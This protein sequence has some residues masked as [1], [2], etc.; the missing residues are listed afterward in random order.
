MEFEQH[1]SGSTTAPTEQ[2]IYPALER[3]TDLLNERVEIRWDDGE[4]YP[5][6]L[7][8]V[9]SSDSG[10]VG[11]VVSFDNEDFE[12]EVIGS[13]DIRLLVQTIDQSTVD[14]E[15]R[16]APV[17]VAGAFDFKSFN[18]YVRWILFPAK[19]VVLSS[20]S[21]S[22]S[23]DEGTDLNEACRPKET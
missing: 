21:Y 11:G 22:R 19:D 4:W 15:G 7:V 20:R 5:G 23:Q 13:D 3:L 12:N 8:A 10:E 2:K 16:N 18:E 14:D 1:H 17:I 6:M 9:R